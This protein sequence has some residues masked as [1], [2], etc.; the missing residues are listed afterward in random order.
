MFTDFLLKFRLLFCFC[1]VFEIRLCVS[2]CAATVLKDSLKIIAGLLNKRLR[3]YSDRDLET[4]RETRKGKRNGE[5]GGKIRNLWYLSMLLCS[6]HMPGK[7]NCFS[8]NFEGFLEF[9]VEKLLHFECKI[10][11]KLSN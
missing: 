5:Q 7:I 2:V 6:T 11:R 8:V 1:S 9:I 3:C 4:L 10:I